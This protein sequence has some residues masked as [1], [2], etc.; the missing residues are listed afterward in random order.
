MTQGEDGGGMKPYSRHGRL[1]AGLAL[2]A[3]LGAAL[4]LGGAV[5]LAQA[6]I[7]GFDGFALIYLCLGLAHLS[8]L[9]PQTLRQRAEDDDEGMAL[10]VLL[11]LAAVGVSFW[12]IFNLLNNPGASGP[13]VILA[14]LAVPLGW[15]AVQMVAG[16][17]FAHLHYLQSGT[18]PLQFAGAQEPGP[19]D[20]MYFA[21]T[22]GMTAQVSDVVVTTTRLRRAVLVHSVL[23]F[24]YNAVILSLAVNAGLKLI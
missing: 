21:F 8:A 3:G 4:L 20:F 2:G 6:V 7:L 5:P 18:A 9:T 14:L 13:L 1:L 16:F 12:A 15:A 24:F 22:I 17:H 10:I 23:S 19:W 11:V